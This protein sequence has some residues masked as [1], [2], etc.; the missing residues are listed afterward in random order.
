MR[1]SLVLL[2]SAGLVGCA[3]SQVLR[4]IE[5]PSRQSPLEDELVLSQ[6]AYLPGVALDEPSI[7]TLTANVRRELGVSGVGWPVWERQSTENAQ[8]RRLLLRYQLMVFTRSTQNTPGAIALLSTSWLILPALFGR[9]VHGFSDRQDLIV[10]VSVYDV[11]GRRP[12]SF[13][14]HGAVVLAYDTSAL[15]PVAHDTLHL[16]VNSGISNNGEAERRTWN[17]AVLADFARQLAA[18]TIPL[19]RSATA[20]D[21]TL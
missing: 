4:P 14:D 12:S 10:A 3:P 8:A 18:G 16:I 11:T 19:L 5:S 9:L 1:V 20:H 17:A 21:Q 2:V 6:I 13:Q 15:E 7:A